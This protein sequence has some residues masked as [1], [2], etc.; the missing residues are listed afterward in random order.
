M[1]RRVILAGGGHAHLAV[2]ADWAARPLADTE[3]WLVTSSRHTAY[4][5]MLPGW[6]AGHY[7]ASDLLIDLAPLAEQAGAKLVIADVAG[8]DPAR[9]MLNLSSGEEVRFDLLS[10]ATGGE[11]DIAR[12]A[13][14]GDRLLPVRPVGTFMERWSN[15]LGRQTPGST[16]GIAIAGGGAAGVELALGAEAVVRR[17]FG[18]ASISLV[19]PE[20]GFL[21][22][23]ARQVRKLALAELARRNI[24]VHF[25]HAEG[26]DGGLRLSNG[27]FLPA[28]C[29]IAATGSR[30]PRWLARSGLA[31]NAAGFV[32]V[33]ADLQSI[34][35]G[36]IFAAGDIIDRVDRRLERS[37]VHAVK[38]GPVLAANL[39]AALNGA[40]LRQYQPRRRTLYLLATGERRA[41]VSWGGLVA[42]GH[43]AWV[44]KD[45]IDRGFVKRYRWPQGHGGSRPK[46]EQGQ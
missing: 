1:T 6:L 17:L 46:G 2:L 38:A 42:A 15:F 19:T 22:G 45:W 16:I 32:S 14:L 23:H 34:S 21:S 25:A 36:A 35:H 29:V 30:P 37:G 26:V 24:A 3:R 43:W 40:V 7:Q 44:I 12:L 18:T 33:G 27:N 39:R 4:S 8:L 13:A 11:T 31:C 5:G 28:D 9:Q 41:I 10:L 20:A